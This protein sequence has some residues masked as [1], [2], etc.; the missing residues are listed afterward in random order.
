MVDSVRMGGFSGNYDMATR[1]TE[2]R[3]G[4]SAQDALIIRELDRAPSE[5]EIDRLGARVDKVD[6]G[7]YR[8]MS[9]TAPAAYTPNS[10]PPRRKAY[11]FDEHP[12][13]TGEAPQGDAP[14]KPIMVNGRVTDPK[15]IGKQIP[16][17]PQAPTSGNLL[18]PSGN[19]L[20]NQHL[21]PPPNN[22][23]TPGFFKV[24]TSTLCTPDQPMTFRRIPPPPFLAWG[25]HRI[26]LLLSRLIRAMRMRL[27][28]IH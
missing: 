24:I 1:L 18:H 28:G 14:V 3:G 27:P 8:E 26:T 19:S 11:G 21:T 17:T 16:H 20:S 22:G 12:S 9:R 4:D 2:R 7:E 25:R 15:Y 10:S 5:A 23:V 13:K 6:I